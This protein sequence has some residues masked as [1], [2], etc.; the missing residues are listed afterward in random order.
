MA[1][2][3][4]DTTLDTTIVYKAITGEAA[5][6]D[7]EAKHRWDEETLPSISEKYV[8]RDI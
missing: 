4:N 6:L 8:D 7:I 5:S 2:G 1:V 3:Y